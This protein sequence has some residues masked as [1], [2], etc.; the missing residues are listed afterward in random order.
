MRY[1]IAL[2]TFSEEFTP[3]SDRFEEEARQQQS[4]AM[5]QGEAAARS[6]KFG[7]TGK[8]TSFNLPA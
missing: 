5:K 4:G 7:G 8:L 2:R 3:A 6:S 1:A